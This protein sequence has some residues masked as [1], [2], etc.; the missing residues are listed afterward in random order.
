MYKVGSIISF[1]SNAS[2][3]VLIHF[4][5]TPDLFGDVQFHGRPRKEQH[6]GKW[7]RSNSSS[8]FADQCLALSRSWILGDFLKREASSTRQWI[9]ETALWKA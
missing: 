5:V 8:G 4:H 2:N 3:E 7:P 1:R 6:S 9:L